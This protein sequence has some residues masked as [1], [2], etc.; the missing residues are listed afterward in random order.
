MSYL[1]YVANA[2]ERETGISFAHLMSA[3][4]ILGITTKD[5]RAQIF[6]IMIEGNRN[7]ANAMDTTLT[8]VNLL[9]R[10]EVK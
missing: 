8:I 1:Q 4:P 6:E 10:W 5:Q 3:H 7:Q 2:I 9:N